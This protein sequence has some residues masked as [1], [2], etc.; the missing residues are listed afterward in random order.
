MLYCM[1]AN[2]KKGWEDGIV[3]L[4]SKEFQK[5]PTKILSNQ[6]FMTTFWNFF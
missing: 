5:M 4:S 1:C 2:L 6:P 3:Y